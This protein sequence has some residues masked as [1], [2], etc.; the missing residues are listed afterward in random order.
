MTA[1]EVLS[2]LLNPPH[3]LAVASSVP[4]PGSGSKAMHPHTNISRALLPRTGRKQTTPG[5]HLCL[6]AFVQR[7]SSLHQH[8]LTSL[9]FSDSKEGKQDPIREKP[10]P[11]TSSSAVQGLTYHGPD[12]AS[13]SSL[14][15]VRLLLQLTEVTLSGQLQPRD[16]RQPGGAPSPTAPGLATCETAGKEQPSSSGSWMGVDR[17]PCITNSGINRLIHGTQ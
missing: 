14:P 1:E 15:S 17:D 13:I 5:F 12:K 8:F 11:I 10:L 7:R 3:H 6:E 9:T 2:Q 16:S 4:P